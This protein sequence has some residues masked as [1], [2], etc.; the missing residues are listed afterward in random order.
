MQRWLLGA[1]LAAAALAGTVAAAQGGGTG[2]QTV[3]LYEK[4]AKLKFTQADVP[5][6]SVKGSV[7][8]GDAFTI[9]GPVFDGVA[10][11]RQVGQVYGLT[12]A[13][14]AAKSFGR[15]SYLAHVV[16]VL[17]GGTMVVDGVFSEA[18][19]TGTFAVTGG[20]GAYAGARGTY[21]PRE[22]ANGNELETIRLL[23]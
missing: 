14:E 10:R 12:T 1:T 18:Q 9:R 2:G 15:G 6:K 16:Y 11:A 23:R 19:Q 22:L 4:D 3:L 13:L 17:K 5:P 7:S 8:A 21:S 20:T